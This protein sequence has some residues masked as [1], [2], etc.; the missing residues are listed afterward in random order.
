MVNPLTVGRCSDSYS[1]AGPL[2]LKN[3]ELWMIQFA[4]STSV[5]RF[6]LTAL[7]LKTTP[8]GFTY[9]I[10]AMFISID[11]SSTDISFDLIFFF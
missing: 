3:L 5:G 4:G 11:A 6:K 9:C 1:V 7:S 10:F 2:A 8:C